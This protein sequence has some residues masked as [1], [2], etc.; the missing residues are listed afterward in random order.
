MSTAPAV[1]RVRLAELLATLSLGT[2]LGMG[3]PMEHVIRQ[4]LIALR[5][6]ER[7]GLG[8]AERRVLYYVGLLAWVGCHVDA[9]E[10]AKWFGD[11]TVFKGDQRRYDTGRPLPAAAFVLGHLGSGRG[12][13][14]RARLGVAF[15]GD[16]RGAVQEM[17]ENHW[18]ATNE[19]AA[20]LELGDDVRDSLYQT[21]ERWDGRGVPAQARGPEIAPAARL[22]S[23][24]DVVEVFHQ[25]GGVEAAVAVARERSGTQF[26]P[27]LVELFCAEAPDLFAELEPVASWDAV[28]AA[29]PALAMMLSE[30]ELERALEAIADFV[31][32]KSPWTLGHS[33]GVAKLAEEAA[34][35]LGLPADD[36]VLVRRAALLHDL[37]RLGVPNSIWDKPG[38][39]SAAEMERV[40]L[41]PYLTGRMLAF[42]PALAGLREVAIQHSER[43]D[44]SGY[45]RG[46]AGNAMT[47]AGKLLAAADAYHAMKEP[48]PFRPALSADAAADELRAGVRGGLFAADAA[49]AVLQAA[50]HPVKRRRQLPAGLTARELE[51]LRLLVRGLSNREIAERLVISRKTAGTH[52]EHIYAKL[53]VS[54]RARASLFAMKHGL[55][56]DE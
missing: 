26:D 10:Q 15:L 6:A 33:R 7:L 18:I 41:H 43:L 27:E 1:T 54:N 14:E 31:D 49:E 46:L 16:G 23:L 47:P 52:V 45:P 55:I 42:S 34:R 24:A 17:M 48:R 50:G 44:G 39:L 51:V 37:G 9:Y 29:E 30:E 40:R 8:E 20:R 11:D 19:L 35:V 56:A 12:L 36:I 5:L 3:Q 32:V 25:A 53:G 38:P 4:S 28:I 2:D 21:F 13:R 22:V